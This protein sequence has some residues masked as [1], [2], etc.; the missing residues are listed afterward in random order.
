MK[1][2]L[3][4]VGILFLLLGIFNIYWGYRD[5]HGLWNKQGVMSL[6]MLYVGTSL[7]IIGFG[8]A[9]AMLKRFALYTAP[10]MS[11]LGIF[12]SLMCAMYPF[13]AVLVLIFV[14]T[15]ICSITYLFQ[16]RIKT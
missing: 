6:I 14:G 13:N 7:L 4:L 2:F 11:I 9:L 10:L 16:S 8:I 3:R 12:Y 5:I 15:I 1:I